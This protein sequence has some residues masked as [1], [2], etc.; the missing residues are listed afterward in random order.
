V[1]T[2][3]GRPFNLADRGA[4]V[5]VMGQQVDIDSAT[6]TGDVQL[7]VSSD[8][9]PSVR[10]QAGID[11]LM[12]GDSREARKLIWNVM[13][14]KHSSNKAL[15]YWLIA[16]LSGRTVQQFTKYE[17][18]QLRYS[19]SWYV[20]ADGD[21]WADGVRLIYRL[22]DSTLP[23][24]PEKQTAE[25]DM[26]LLVK[27]VEALE[28][29]QRDLIRPHLELFLAGPLQDEVWRHELLIARHRQ[30]GDGRGE[31]AWMFFQ[32][33]PAEASLPLP[34]PPRVSRGDQL[35]VRTCACL[36]AAAAGYLG[37]KL[38]WQGNV[39][40]LLSYVVGLTGGLVTVAADLEWR[41]VTERNRQRDKQL[42]LSGENTTESS[43]ELA[44]G[45]DKLFTR[46]YNNYAADKAEKQA[47]DSATAGIR[48]FLRDE[49]I[50]MCLRSG[51]QANSMAWLIR[52]EV[53]DL[54][55]HWQDGSLHEYRRQLALRPHTVAARRAGLVLALCGAWAIFSLRAHPLA[56]AVALL[57]A[58]GTWCYWL[59]A[60]LEHRRHTAD[61]E[62]RAERQSAIDEEFRRWS[63]KL[64]ARPTDEEMAIWLARD[65][66]V[67]LGTALDHFHLPRSQVI[68]HAFLEH[69]GVAVKRGRIEGG[70]W[71]YGGYLFQAFL[72]GE[73]GVRQ[74]RANLNFV[75]GTLDIR[76]RTSYPHD[77]IVAVR[78]LKERRRQTFKI[79]LTAGDPIIVR[80]R[81]TDVGGTQQDQPAEPAD[82]TQEAAE[83]DEEATADATSVAD[84][85]HML[86]RSIAEKK[87]WFQE[88]DRTGTWPG[89]NDA[90]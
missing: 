58:F 24:S 59:R 57:S 4:N 52:H 30:R 50:G 17:N 38:L 63:G 22:L 7:T 44:A 39:L 29:T 51:N 32:P 73:D 23:S 33:V 89:D 19:R 36:F 62:E 53:R 11:N 5:G 65:R 86:E 12:H 72:L 18:S 75:T 25:P 78:F 61:S 28:V 35:L 48:R 71:R 49:I 87:N 68:E 88:R 77:S 83:P 10:F 56:I 79:T 76:E 16:M 27:Q 43:D 84:L 67:L 60:S 41:F 82:E 90:R 54:K 15:F 40:G 45:I 47:W 34:Y 3:H 13:I 66:A 55:R 37:W 64:E 6:F 8:A 9:P 1:T 42:G 85:L 21:A 2:Q 26:R 69:P 46:Y 14:S 70:P 81:N 80:L 74:V 20:P 31:R